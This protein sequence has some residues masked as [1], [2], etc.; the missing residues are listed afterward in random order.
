MANRSGPPLVS[1][2]KRTNY[3][4]KNAPFVN[5]DM[6]DS[7]LSLVYPNLRA[8]VTRPSRNTKIKAVAAFLAD[9]RRIACRAGAYGRRNIGQE[10]IMVCIALFKDAD[11]SLPTRDVDP[12]KNHVVIKAIHIGGGTNPTAYLA[13]A[14]VQPNEPRRR[15]YPNK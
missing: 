2:L 10:A 7:I 12:F 1:I 14:G 4:K 8:V 9:L 6:A 11:E 5:C 3:P 15:S 13:G